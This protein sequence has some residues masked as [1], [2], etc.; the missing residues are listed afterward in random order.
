MKFLYFCSVIS[1]SEG[2][3]GSEKSLAASSREGNRGRSSPHADS[4]RGSGLGVPVSGCGSPGRVQ[5]GAPR[6]APR[7]A[8]RAQQ[9]RASLCSSHPAWHVL[10]AE[11]SEHGSH[12]GQL[13]ASSK[14]LVTGNELSRTSRQ[15]KR[16]WLTCCW[17]FRFASLGSLPCFGG[18][19]HEALRPRLNARLHCTAAGGAWGCWAG[20]EPGGEGGWN[21]ASA[22]AGLSGT[23][24]LSLQ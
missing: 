24:T 12:K 13:G 10:L 9:L 18:K 22:A 3:G 8:G 5:K 7:A 19:A 4:G 14:P 6:S 11:P 1:C 15:G 21:D 2:E 20:A 17:P 23:L 16:C